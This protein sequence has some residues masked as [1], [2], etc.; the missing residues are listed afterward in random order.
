MSLCK[1]LKYEI[2]LGLFGR[3]LEFGERASN[4]LLFKYVENR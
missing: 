2:W 3:V 4:S 1:D